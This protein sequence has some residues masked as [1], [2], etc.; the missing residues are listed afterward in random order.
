MA[1][2]VAAEHVVGLVFGALPSSF[3][4]FSSHFR[5]APCR[6]QLAAGLTVVLGL[7]VRTTAPYFPLC[8][9]WASS[10][11]LRGESWEQIWA[12]WQ[13]Y[14]DFVGLWSPEDRGVTLWLD[15]WEMN[16]RQPLR[17]QSEPSCLLS[18]RQL[19]SLVFCLFFSYLTLAVSFI[20]QA[21]TRLLVRAARVEAGPRHADSNGPER[22]HTDHRV[23]C[24]LL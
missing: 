14:A 8:F 5:L 4:S 6:S 7:L 12:A 22:L 3:Q 15:G 17:S 20:Q 10:L 9:G 1:V 18:P 2:A 24:F 16:T 19:N 21:R 11:I 13:G 23:L